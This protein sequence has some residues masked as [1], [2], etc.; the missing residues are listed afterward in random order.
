MEISRGYRYICKNPRLYV[1]PYLSEICICFHVFIPPVMNARQ[2]GCCFHFKNES[3]ESLLKLLIFK[4][5]AVSRRYRHVLFLCFSFDCIIRKS[6]YSE[7]GYSVRKDE[8][9]HHYSRPTESTAY[10]SYPAISF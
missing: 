1:C 2:T 10:Q 7:T 3:M 8:H 4:D 6:L 5:M 9:T